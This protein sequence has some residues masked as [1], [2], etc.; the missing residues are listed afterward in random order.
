VCGTLCGLRRAAPRGFFLGAHGMKALVLREHGGLDNLAF[1]PDF[2]DP[3]PGDGEVVV[4]VRATSLNYHDVFTRRGMPGITI[5]MPAIMGID[6]AGE[7]AKIGP[8]VTGWKIGDRVVI[9]PVNRLGKGL[10][11]ETSH[12]GLAELCRTQADQLV[13]L[14][15]DIS[16]EQAAA[17]P[18]AY[19]T[20]Y[21]MMITNGRIAAGET[22]LILGA[23]GGVGVCCVMLAKSVGATVI[24]CASTN[25]KCEK[26]RQIG[27]DSTINYTDVDFLEYVHRTFGRPLRRGPGRGGGVDVVVNYTGGDTWVRSLRCLRRGGRLL[28]CGATA[29][30]DPAEDLRYVWTFELNICGSNS[31]QREDLVGLIG[32]VQ[33]QELTAIIDKTY[34]LDQGREALAALEDRT[35]FGKVIVTP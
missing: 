4:R 20:A 2:P 31:F 32:M 26:L 8:G 22:V 21:R 25:E 13:P 5:P 12:G 34:P 3:E 23:S 30:F 18:I 29:G 6:V 16:F 35:V 11:G 15:D 19:G 1:D 7:V 14:P 24:A 28:T 10:L 33:R 27:A 17:L 9:D